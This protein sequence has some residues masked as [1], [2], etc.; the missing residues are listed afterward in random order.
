M[1][2]QLYTFVPGLMKFMDKFSDVRC[3]FKFLCPQILL[4]K[5]GSRVVF[6]ETLTHFMDY[7]AYLATVPWDVSLVGLYDH[8]FNDAKSD[9]KLVELAPHEIPII[10]S[11]RADFYQ[12]KDRNIMLYADD[13]RPEM[14]WYEMLKK[15]YTDR[16]EIN[17]MKLRAKEFIYEERTSK[18]ISEK[19]LQI[20]NRF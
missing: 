16:E 9:M 14:S 10:A 5:Y 2:D 13:A 11:P 1:A 17:A 4:D 8:P 20:L 19:W 12:H 3:H 18:K 15:A 7:P 6:D